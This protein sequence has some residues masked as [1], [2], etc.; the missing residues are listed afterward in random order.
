MSTIWIGKGWS[1]YDVLQEWDSQPGVTLGKGL[2]NPTLL[3]CFTRK[4]LHWIKASLHPTSSTTLITIDWLIDTFW[5]LPDKLCSICCWS[6]QRWLM[7]WC[8][9]L[10]GRTPCKPTRRL[11]QWVFALS[12]VQPAMILL[13]GERIPGVQQD[14]N[15][16]LHG[17]CVDWAHSIVP[18][19]YCYLGKGEM[20]LKRQATGCCLV[21]SL[22]HL[23]CI[24]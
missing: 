23:R 1:I 13:F 8:N 21:I 7:R 5:S 16:K 4:M 17:G 6:Y 12:I 24:K 2:R 19:A 14:Y 15:P 3:I 11:P 10:G 20:V 22:C 9:H 18:K